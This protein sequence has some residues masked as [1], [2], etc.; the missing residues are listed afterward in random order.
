MFVAQLIPHPQTAN[1]LTL[2]LPGMVIG[3]GFY[4][5]PQEDLTHSGRHIQGPIPQ[6]ECQGQ[7]WKR[8]DILQ[9]R[10]FAQVVGQKDRSNQMWEQK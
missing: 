10:S 6:A 2:Y 4:E 8:L 7:K 9:P 3:G 5:A 1:L